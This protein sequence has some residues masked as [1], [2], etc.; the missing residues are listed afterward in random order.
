MTDSY[1]NVEDVL[2]PI[3]EGESMWPHNSHAVE[4]GAVERAVLLA[5]GKP[6]DGA[7]GVPLL[8]RGSSAFEPIRRL[9]DAVFRKAGGWSDRDFFIAPCDRCLRDVQPKHSLWVSAGATVVDVHCC[10]R[11]R[12]D[13][14]ADFVHPPL[15]WS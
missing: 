10:E 2:R 3:E 15:I 11:C 8:R 4:D 13:L 5:F 6:T 7:R 12:R 14:D 1:R 9:F